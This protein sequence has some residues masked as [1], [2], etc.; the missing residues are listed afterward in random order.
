[1]SV[2]VSVSVSAS[3]GSRAFWVNFRWA[4][5]VLM[6]RGSGSDGPQPPVRVESL[7]EFVSVTED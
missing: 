3:A 6:S 7:R 5:P 2:S 1:M 4:E